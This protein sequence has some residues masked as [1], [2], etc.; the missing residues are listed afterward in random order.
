MSWTCLP[1]WSPWPL[2]NSLLQ[3]LLQDCPN[4]L[5]LNSWPPM[6]PMKWSTTR[7]TTSS[8]TWNW[9]GSSH[10]GC[11]MLSSPICALLKVTTRS[12]WIVPHTFAMLAPVPIAPMIRALW[13]DTCV[14]T[15][16]KSLLNVPFATLD[17]LPKPTAKGM[18]RTS[19]ANPLGKRSVIPSSSMKVL[20]ANPCPIMVTS[21]CWTLPWLNPME[22]TL[23]GTLSEKTTLL[24]LPR[25]GGMTADWSM[26][27]S[28]LLTEAQCTDLSKNL[29]M[30]MRPKLKILT[31]MSQMHLWI[32]AD[33]TPVTL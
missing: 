13:P 16:E 27:E 8:G 32:W 23:P 1:R 4:L 3:T 12:I 22:A 11:V 20:K 25:K 30:S 26:S 29:T 24:L 15:L 5:Q 31:N 14:L 28:L 33:Q 17:S 7:M 10:A 21:T 6:I 2:R 19:M 18:W 9:K